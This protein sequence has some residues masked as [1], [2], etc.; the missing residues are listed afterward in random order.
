MFDK[1]EVVY[2][3]ILTREKY[4]NSRDNISININ[5]LAINLVYGFTFFLNNTYA[6]LY[7]IPPSTVL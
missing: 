2:I 5:Y 6:I 1:P 3:K 7:T 4:I